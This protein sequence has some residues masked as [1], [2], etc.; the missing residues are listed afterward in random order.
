LWQ[1]SWL[2]AVGAIPLKRRLPGYPVTAFTFVLLTV[3]ETAFAFHEIP[4]YLDLSTI[5]SRGQ[6]FWEEV[7]GQGNYE[8]RELDLQR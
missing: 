3:A 6:F 5:K 8:P 2:A 7:I 4:Y 1:V